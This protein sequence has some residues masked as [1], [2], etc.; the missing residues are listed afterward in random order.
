MIL[1]IFK[2]NHKRFGSVLAA[3]SLATGMLVSG[4]VA[5]TPAG[6]QYKCNQTG[7]SPCMT[8]QYPAFPRGGPTGFT[9]SC[10]PYQPPGRAPGFSFGCAPFIPQV[11]MPFFFG[12][13]LITETINSVEFPV[14]GI[15]GGSAP[16]SKDR[17][18]SLLP[19]LKNESEIPDTTRSTKTDFSNLVDGVFKTGDAQTDPAC[20]DA[21]KLCK[22]GKYQDAL[23]AIDKE[24]G[25]ATGMCKY[26][27]AN[28]NLGLGKLEDALKDIQESQQLDP[29]FAPGYL[30]E[31]TILSELNRLPEAVK[32]YTKALALRPTYV[33]CLDARG[34]AYYR[35]GQFLDSIRDYELALRQQPNDANS[36]YMRG[37]CYFM[38]GQFQMV[39][40]CYNEYLSFHPNDTAALANRG[41]A[42]FELGKYQEALA[43]FNR[44]LS[45]DAN[46]LTCLYKRCLVYWHLGRWH[47]A[48]TDANASLKVSGWKGEN[49][50]YLALCAY[51]LS[52]KDNQPDV[53]NVL[54]QDSLKNLDSKDW[55]YPLFLYFDKKITEADLFQMAISKEQWTQA[56]T[57][58][59]MKLAWTK[60]NEKAPDYAARL[61][62]K[63]R[64]LALLEQVR[65]QGASNVPEYNLAVNE[66]FR[67]KV[68]DVT[69]VSRPVKN[70]YALVVGVSK[71]KDTAINLR[72]SDKDAEDFGN[73]LVSTE[74]FPK[75]N[76]KVLLNQEATRE[77]IL[78]ALGESW[79]PRK[80]NKDDLVLVYFSTHG[81]PS[82]M[83]AK[84]INYL[85]AHDTDKDLLYATGIP[86]QDLTRLIKDKV[87]ADRVVV[88]MD[89]CHSGSAK[90]DDRLK[91]DATDMA[92]ES[93]QAVICSSLPEE[94]SWESKQYSNSVFTRHLIDGFKCKGAK[95]SI[96]DTFDYAKN[97]VEKE[98][99]DDRKSKQ[100]PVMKS[101]WAKADLAIAA[102]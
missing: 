20:K 83:D 86:V 74:G 5:D 101:T 37:L 89:A 79:L 7:M 62:E 87:H 85:L 76:V 41:S 72:Y 6:A 15:T 31:G 10:Q 25:P 32:A 39:P 97:H 35:M 73:F 3:L 12:P 65:A 70:K 58:V 95:T 49:S 91:L 30:T 68:K 21:A 66:M 13:S 94:V 27:R 77:N 50:A 67:N 59:A 43:D 23:S 40:I 71:F 69:N 38:V 102:P 56:R 63:S 42:Y 88:I 2:R 14:S 11:P 98:V 8:P 52:I 44:V 29:N 9:Q 75:Q 28:A 53:A 92:N 47:D 17:I 82:A 24:S 26:V 55:P 22:E 84:G 99:W 96:S 4:V 33:R 54:L 80:A 46:D 61:K 64:V 48:V 36:M 19:S 1:S 18:E 60:L 81:S 78:G 93:G 51:L 16:S 90:A 34:G 100:T 57:Y 45:L